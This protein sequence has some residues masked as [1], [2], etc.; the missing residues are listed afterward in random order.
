MS[1]VIRVLKV[2]QREKHRVLKSDRESQSRR[3]KSSSQLERSLC[4]SQ[5]WKISQKGRSGQVRSF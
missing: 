3:L 5:E 1:I 4:R 2:S